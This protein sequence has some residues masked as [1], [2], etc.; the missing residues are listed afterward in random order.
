MAVYIGNGN[1]GSNLNS[2]INFLVSNPLISQ[3]Y[4]AK[5]TCQAQDGSIVFSSRLDRLSIG[6]S[7]IEINPNYNGMIIEVALPN[8]IRNGELKSGNYNV[9]IEL[10]SNQGN[11]DKTK[12]CEGVSSLPMI[13]LMLA[14]PTNFEV[15]KTLN[16]LLFWIP[17]SPIFNTTNFS[18]E[19]K[20]AKILENQS[21]F[22]AIQS[23]LL[24]HHSKGLKQNQLLYPFTSVPLIY[25]ENYAWQVEAWEGNFSLGKSEIWQFSPKVDSLN[26]LLEKYRI[27]S[28]APLS[29]TPP[30]GPVY[31]SDALLFR[32]NYDDSSSWPLSVMS[33]AEPEKV[34]IEINKTDLLDVGDNKYVFIFQNEMHLRKNNTYI[35]K[36]QQLNNNSYLTFTIK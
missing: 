21:S 4:N 18:Y 11:D 15:V 9:C 2:K 34:I 10:V 22:E 7:P 26:D 12:V 20:L 28:F 19:L 3:V 31:C 14:S 32:L 24:M 6:S 13:P 16:P 1:Q 33:S 23:N 27:F 8:Y 5:L 36:Q 35:L 29:S 25:G 17:P 30:S